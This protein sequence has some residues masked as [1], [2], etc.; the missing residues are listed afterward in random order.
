LYLRAQ[1]DLALFAVRAYA[2]GHGAPMTKKRKIVLG[3]AG[4]CLV[5]PVLALAVVSYLG[6]DII[7]W[8]YPA[9]DYD[10]ML[11]REA[12][13]ALPLIKAIDRYR[14]EHSSLPADMADLASY[15]PARPKP[16][17]LPTPESA[18]AQWRYLRLGVASYDLYLKL[19]WDPSLHYRFEGSK[20]YWYF[21][22]GDGN[23]D[24]KIIKLNP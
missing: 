17:K 10:P 2:V 23:E 24:F 16:P 20:G 3:V 11:T 7:R 6:R 1:Q 19:D 15:L 4:G 13:R 12:A 8:D 5:L 9:A 14:G 22:P 21:D 18:K